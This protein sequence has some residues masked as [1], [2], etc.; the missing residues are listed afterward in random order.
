MEKANLSELRF[1]SEILHSIGIKELF[2]AIV[3]ANR[4]EGWNHS[5]LIITSAMAYS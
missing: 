1:V 5:G 2:A 4:M 3:L